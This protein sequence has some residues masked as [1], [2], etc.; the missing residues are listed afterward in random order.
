MTTETGHSD[1]DVAPQTDDGAPTEAHP[2]AAVKP[3]EGDAPAA[4]EQ[5]DLTVLAGGATEKEAE[6]TERLQRVAADYA[7][8]QK[9]VQRDRARWSEEAIR[10][11]VT[12]LL[13]VLDSLD[14]AIAAFDSDVKDAQTY[15]DGVVMVR[16]ELLRQLGNHKVARIEAEDGTPFDPDRHEAILV[17][18]AEGIDEQQVGFVARVGYT[19]GDRV[20]R[21]A[22]VGVK[23]PKA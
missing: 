21:A 18:E 10:D 12:D 5:P 9:R 1:A 15:K 14:Q 23:K 2:E 6:L 3:A 20:L 22:Q 17:Q 16:E 7:N 4:G 11:L 8:Y 19:L 13:P